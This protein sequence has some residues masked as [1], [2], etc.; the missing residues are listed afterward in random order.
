[1][2]Q[3]KILVA[4]DDKNMRFFVRELLEKEQYSVVEACDGQQAIEQYLSHDI[5]LVILDYRMPLLDGIE[6]LTQLK[7]N[8]PDV[9]VLMVTAHDTKDL[10]LEAI[11]KGAYDY[12]TK[13]FDVD[14]IRI[15]IRRSLE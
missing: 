7:M 12:F 1:M 10:A 3:D 4:D 15:I 9:L 2:G 11:R 6:A 14:E 13:P 5:D 8:D